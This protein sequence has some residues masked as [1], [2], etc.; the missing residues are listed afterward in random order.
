MLY[1]IC[2]HVILSGDWDFCQRCSQLYGTLLPASWLLLASSFLFLTFSSSPFK[3]CHEGR[4]RL[5]HTDIIFTFFRR[6]RRQ[7]SAHDLRKGARK[8]WRRIWVAA[9]HAAMAHNHGSSSLNNNNIESGTH[10][11]HNNHNGNSSNSNNNRIMNLGQL[12]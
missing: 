3:P 2:R 6:V 9:K 11:L 1:F 7:L 10:S 4:R 5:T 8:P 12:A